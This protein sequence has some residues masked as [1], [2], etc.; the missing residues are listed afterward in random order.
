M[1][2]NVASNNYIVVTPNGNVK[3]FKEEDEAHN[4]I[5]GY[6][7]RK[8]DKFSDDME[9]TYEDYATNPIESTIDICIGLGVNEGDCTIYDLDDFI[10]KIQKSDMF[11]DEKEEVIS[12]LL[13]TNVELNVI[14]YELFGILRDVTVIP[15]R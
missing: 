9:M 8:V 1:Q 12:K 4:F 10:D 2:Y 13:K 7:E 14:D 15:H 6:Y 11:D 3:G 5:I